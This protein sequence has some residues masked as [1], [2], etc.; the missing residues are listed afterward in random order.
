MEVCAGYQT[1]LDREVIF[2]EIP[3]DF[4]RMLRETDVSE[5][6]VRSIPVDWRMKTRAVFEDLLG[7]GYR[8]ADFQAFKDMDRKRDFYVFQK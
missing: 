7:R 5:P 6:E 2:V 4:Y 1:G 3:F 8:V